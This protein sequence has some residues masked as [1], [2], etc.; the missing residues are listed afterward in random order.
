MMG[1][2]KK[3]GTVYLLHFDEKLHHA[4][5]YLGFAENG[6]LESRIE[7]HRNGTGANIMRV[8]REHGITFQVATTWSGDRKFERRLK[9]RKC[10]GRFCPICKQLKNHNHATNNSQIIH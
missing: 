2:K 4:Q 6:N 9:N 5:H 10:A 8:I 3:S 1:R 7:Q